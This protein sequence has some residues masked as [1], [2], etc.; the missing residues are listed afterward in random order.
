MGKLIP[1]QHA[2]QHRVSVI[3]LLILA[4]SLKPFY[5]EKKK[6]Q[7]IAHW[8]SNPPSRNRQNCRNSLC[9][10]LKQS[11]WLYSHM[12]LLYIARRNS[13]AKETKHNGKNIYTIYIHI[14]IK[15]TFLWWLQ[16][17]LYYKRAP[18]MQF[19]TLIIQLCTVLNA[20]PL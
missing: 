20:I 2:T 14:H 4:M 6:E 11:L 17:I 3:W 7:A 12:G 13:H 19:N 18:E 10:K 15:L 1:G 9:L 8:V 16:I 5:P